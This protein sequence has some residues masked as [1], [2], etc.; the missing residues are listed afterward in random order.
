[1]LEKTPAE[2]NT[3]LSNPSEYTN[4]MRNAGDAQAR[5]NLERV[6]D[7]L[8]RDKCDTFEVRALC[9]LLV[10]LWDQINFSTHFFLYNFSTH[11]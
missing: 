3:Y 10:M 6:L 9:S 8:D 11:L 4:A 2:V 7:C 1:L 5:D